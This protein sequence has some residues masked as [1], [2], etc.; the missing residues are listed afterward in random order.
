MSLQVTPE[1]DY[2]D[3]AKYLLDL[4]VDAHPLSFEKT[5]TLRLPVITAPPLRSDGTAY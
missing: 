5:E 3:L 1:P 2:D 4:Y